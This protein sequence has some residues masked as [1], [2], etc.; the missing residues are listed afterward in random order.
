MG[1]VWVDYGSNMGG[2]WVEYG[3]HMGY[4]SGIW[5]G[6]GWNEVDGMISIV[7]NGK[8]QIF[9]TYFF[10]NVKSQVKFDQIGLDW[11]GMDEN[12]L[13]WMEHGVMYHFQH[14]EG[15]L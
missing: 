15:H 10:D 12:G 5:V 8:F 11:N 14:M 9:K 6:Y 2:V 3:C 1:G 7:K 13:E 4:I